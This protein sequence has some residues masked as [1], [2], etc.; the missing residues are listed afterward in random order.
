MSVQKKWKRQIMVRVCNKESRSTILMSNSFY[1]LLVN[2]WVN[3]S[4]HRSAREWCSNI[5][6]IFWNTFCIQCLIFGET[7]RFVVWSWQD[8][9]GKW[10]RVKLVAFAVV[11]LWRWRDI[12]LFCAI[13]NSILV[14]D[15]FY[16]LKTNITHRLITYS[17]HVQR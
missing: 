17:K 14:Q 15:S 16:S 3:E 6:H 11:K 5:L 10:F 13:I 1:L 7:V 2:Y 12:T 8:K 9:G 4:P